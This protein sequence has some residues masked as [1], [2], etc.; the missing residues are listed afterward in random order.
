MINIDGQEFFAEKIKGNGSYNFILIHNAG[1]NHQFYRYQI[2]TL[3]KY[4][5]IVWLDLPGH[6]KSKGSTL[7]S[8]TTNDL[9]SFIVKIAKHF[10][11]Q[12][13]CLIGLNNGANI[14]LN[15][16][17]NRMMPVERLIL[18]DPILFM[19][20]EFI[21]E[22]NYFIKRFA[23]PELAEFLA[24]LGDAFFIKTTEINK[25]IAI[26]SF[27]NVDIRSL[28]EVFRGLIASNV[29]L[30]NLS[31][32]NLPALAILTNEHHCPYAPLK[33]SAPHIQISKV[34]NSK[35][36]ATLEV[37]DQINPMI[38]SFLSL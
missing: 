20:E 10:L 3:K 5:D 2:D 15:I 6:N 33:Q 32:I 34:V 35:N 28:Q 21:G 4:G 24:S 26:D 12:N 29:D 36:W 25:K 31:N 38:E 8:Y 22:I 30:T 14:A 17:L 23:E 9:S 19:N 16:V 18:V 27:A 7:S 37:P 11:L 13:V 1:G